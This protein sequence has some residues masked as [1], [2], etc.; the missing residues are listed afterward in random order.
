MSCR[1]RLL[2]ERPLCGVCKASPQPHKRAGVG[3]GGHAPPAGGSHANPTPILQ[4]HRPCLSPSPAG[5]EPV[6]NSPSDQASDRPPAAASP[7]CCTGCAGGS[8]GPGGL[9]H[10]C[11]GCLTCGTQRPTSVPARR[12]RAHLDCPRA[13]PVA[14]APLCAPPGGT[15]LVCTR[16]R[17]P[18]AWT[19]SW[20]PRRAGGEPGSAPSTW[21]P[22]G[23]RDRAGL[24]SGPSCG[25]RRPAACSR[26]WPSPR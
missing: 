7:T 24:P 15:G 10:T 19:A 13:R 21:P 20:M 9:R 16:P 4:G 2:S 3:P 25:R 14:Q 6:L 1:S 18:P 12:G 26:A 5:R 17:Q 23:Q 11:P 22:A 8:P